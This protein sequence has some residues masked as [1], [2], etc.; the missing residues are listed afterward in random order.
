MLNGVFKVAP[1]RLQPDF[2]V[3]LQDQISVAQRGEDEKE[4]EAKRWTPRDCARNPVPCDR[5]V[6]LYRGDGLLLN[7]IEKWDAAAFVPFP[8][9]LLSS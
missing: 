2:S 8:G 4:S 7:D 6:R 3:W 1:H 5:A 9:R